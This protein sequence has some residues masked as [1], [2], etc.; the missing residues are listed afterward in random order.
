M[1]VCG[2]EIGGRSLWGDAHEDTDGR[3]RLHLVARQNL[4]HET[5]H[6]R[7]TQEVGNEKKKNNVYEPKAFP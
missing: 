3:E 7:S 2:G 5:K 4:R 6:P 1:G